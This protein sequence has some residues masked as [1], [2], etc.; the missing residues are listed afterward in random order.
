MCAAVLFI[1]SNL[2]IRVLIV[3]DSF[4]GKLVALLFA[5]KKEKVSRLNLQAW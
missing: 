4:S 2:Y 3:T 5:T 1:T